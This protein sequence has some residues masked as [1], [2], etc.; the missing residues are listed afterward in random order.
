MVVKAAMIFR[1]SV[2]LKS[3]GLSGPIELEETHA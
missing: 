1:P 3:D 2:D